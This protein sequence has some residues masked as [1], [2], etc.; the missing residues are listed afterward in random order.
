[1]QVKPFL[2]MPI[3][4]GLLGAPSAIAAPLAEISLDNN[5]IRNQT[6]TSDG[7]RVV[8]TA[9]DPKNDTN[10][11]QTNL[12]YEIYINDELKVQEQ[13]DAWWHGSLS[14]QNLDADTI[15]EVV[16]STY[17]GGAHCCTILTLYSWQGDR[18]HRN[19][20]YPL[21]GFAGQFEDLDG[22]G[23]SEFV[24]VDNRFLYA[25]SS[26]A[27][28]YPPLIILS[29]QDGFWVDVTRT[30]PEM[31]RSHAYGMYERTRTGHSI[32]INGTLAGY[33]AQK[34]LMDEYQSGWDYMQVH[35][36][37]EDSWGLTVTNLDGEVVHNYPDFPA[38]LSAFLIDTGYLTNTGEPNTDLDLSDFIFEQ[39][40]FQE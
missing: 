2:L 13:T 16:V 29:L 5:P 14:L 25:F 11:E 18:L 28:S 17:T 38:A 27:G 33:V 32:E 31:Q 23:N 7:V 37:Q 1:M 24:T 20:T 40:S 26:Y 22:D 4:L 8:V 34:I 36:N 30:F 19:Q 12:S 6:I 10:F 3:V 21:D 15:P 9:Y 39:A 35:Y